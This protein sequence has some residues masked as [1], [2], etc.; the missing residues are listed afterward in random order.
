MSGKERSGEEKYIL[1]IDH[2]TSGAKCAI[3]SVHGEVVDWVFKE[4]PLIFP[5][6]DAAEQ[7]PDAW[8]NA[9]KEATKELVDKNLVRVEDIVGISN[10]SQWSGTVPLDKDGNHLMNAIIWMDS[11]GAKQLEKFVKGPIMV[12]GYALSKI[13]KFLK[14]TMGGPSLSGK[15]PICH[16][17]WLKD[18]RP[19][20]YEKTAMFLEPQDY[21]N[22]KLTGEIA[23]SHAAMHVHWLLDIRNPSN[24]HY[25]DSILKMVKFTKDKFPPLKRSID[26]LG[27]IKPS[28]ADE[29]GLEKS[30]KVVL[31]A[32]DLHAATVGSGAV[33][34]YEAHI[35]IGTSDWVLCHVPFTKVDIKHNIGT[36]PSAFPGKY[37][38]ANEQ[39]IAGGALSFLR[40]EILYHKDELL[41]EEKMPDVYKIF[42]SIVEKVP[43]GSNNLIFT[44]WLYGE[45]SPIPNHSV[46]AGLYN[47]SMDT[48]REHIIRA[49]FEGVAF[50]V[51]WLHHY[52]EKFAK[53]R[54]DNI[55]IIGGGANSNVW[56]QIFADVLD[57]TIHQVENPIQA[58]ARGAAMIG[59]VGLGYI[60]TEEIGKYTR[61][62]RV[63][64]P[65]RDHRAVY[66]NLFKEYKNIY[67]A[68][69]GIYKRLNKH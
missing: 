56:C 22:Y 60:K 66:D 41:L 45:R 54:L 69:K 55:R 30:T 23:S 39:E 13:L 3:I 5:E 50:N 59:A 37:I 29:L 57:R 67:K 42:D 36:I 26:I 47:L 9:I 43:V 53:H 38:A 46:R 49:V 20:I 32:P 63:F 35:C 12:D 31:G 51:R 64:K 7:D 19:E 61:V 15:D 34:D 16:I 25:S 44:P 58:N 24:I 17:M 1:A 18:E 21:V 27:P 68:M 40:D 11:R 62:A 14:V 28:L 10:T 4:V 6:P 2:G 52:M 8:W 33:G 65:N 48:N